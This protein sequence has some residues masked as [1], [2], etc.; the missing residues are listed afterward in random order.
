MLL[1]ALTGRP[2]APERINETVDRDGFV[3]AQHQQGEQRGLLAATQ[4][5]RTAVIPDFERAE[6][7]NSTCSSRSTI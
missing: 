6:H 3:R 2:L 5:E 1:A 4:R 7:T